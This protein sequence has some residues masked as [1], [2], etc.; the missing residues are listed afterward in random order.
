MACLSAMTKNNCR[1]CGPNV[2]FVGHACLHCKQPL[3]G[4]KPRGERA[5]VFHSANA[6]A[7]ALEAGIRAKRQTAATP[8]PRK[9]SG[10]GVHGAGR[11]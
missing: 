2:L 11:T 5:A 4:P 7:A 6:N 8:V 1:V 3:S 9:G 10:K